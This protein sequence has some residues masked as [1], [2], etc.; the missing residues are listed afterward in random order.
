MRDFVDPN[1][2]TVPNHPADGTPVLISG[3]VVSQSSK[4]CQPGEL[5]IIPQLFHVGDETVCRGKIIIGNLESCGERE[6][7]SGYGPRLSKW[8]GIAVHTM[9]VGSVRAWEE[10]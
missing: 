8:D 2:T 10:E 3:D 1:G 4:K 6:P 7:D 9:S 5:A